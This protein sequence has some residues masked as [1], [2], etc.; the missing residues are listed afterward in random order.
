M[1]FLTI[2]LL[3][4]LAIS[5]MGCCGIVPDPFQP[6]PQPPDP[7]PPINNSPT[8]PYAQDPNQPDPT[9]PYQPNNNT[10]ADPTQS[11]N[12]Q[13]SDPNSNNFELTSGTP[14]LFYTAPLSSVSSNIVISVSDLAGNYY[15]DTLTIQKSTTAVLAYLPTLNTVR[16][17][18]EATSTSYSK[19]VA[20]PYTSGQRFF[21]A[22]DWESDWDIKDTSWTLEEI[23]PITGNQKGSSTFSADGFAVVGNN[24][25]YRSPRESN[26]YG[27]Y[28]GGELMSMPFGQSSSGTELQTYDSSRGWL[29]AIGN[30]LIT[31]P[32]DVT[33]KTYSIRLH[34]LQT[35]AV[36][37]T[38]YSDIPYSVS[39]K[40]FPGENALYQVV[41][42]GTKTYEI[43]RYP[44]TGSAETLLEV[45]LEAGEKDVYVAEDDNMVA[46]FI[47]DDS[48]RVSHLYLH[49]YVKRT[50]EEV[51]IEPFSSSVS[52]TRIGVPFFIVD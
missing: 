31:T 3:A 1:K 15:G 34:N 20:Y 10:P 21:V 18:K 16:V 22:R 44:I 35:G 45:E 43:D 29:Y 12:T 26:A 14:V 36:S 25:F 2:I 49:D 42:T 52:F 39:P 47:I 5:L 7:Y 38:L 51:S 11:N 23:D 46:L 48:N 28:T 40:L 33:Q 50:T 13:P 4:V 8:D 19:N 6:L 41:E 27:G 17:L 32:L 30:N 9:N 24:I 37:S